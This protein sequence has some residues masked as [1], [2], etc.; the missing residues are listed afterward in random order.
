MAAR[1]DEL[2]AGEIDQIERARARASR[3]A[4][5][6]E[7]LTELAVGVAFVVAAVAMAVYIPHDRAD[8]GVF[9]WLAAICAVLVRIEFEVGEGNTR[10]VQLGFV[11]LLL[12]VSPGLVPLA[13][14]FAYLPVRL[15]RVLRRRIPPQRLLLPIADSSFAVAPALVMACFGSLESVWATAG[16]CLLALVAL[17]GSDLGISWFRMRVGLGMD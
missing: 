12:L 15:V 2:S 13:V 1:L 11:P 8:W 14:M 5:R 9:V 6:R 7:L 17:M 4:E 10:P 3:H 16:A